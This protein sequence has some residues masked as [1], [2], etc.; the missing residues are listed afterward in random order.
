MDSDFVPSI[1]PDA[2]TRAIKAATRDLKDLAG[3]WERV[4]RIVGRATS[5]V[6]RWGSLAIDDLDHVIPIRAA[7]AL[8]ADTGQP[9]VTQAMA[10]LNGR[11]LG[12]GAAERQRTVLA[13]HS[14]V[15]RSV[16][17]YQAG[18]ADAIEDGVLTPTELNGLA[19]RAGLIS[20]AATRMQFITS[21][22]A[23]AAAPCA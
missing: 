13:A 3:G 5:T 11:S 16:S 18:F 4:A 6:Q 17:A 9:L 14:A 22:E 15:A 20:Q 21:A 10:D 8:E 2:T 23:G 7:L 19:E 12:P 1:E